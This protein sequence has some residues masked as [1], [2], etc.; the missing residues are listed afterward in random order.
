MQHTSP[1]AYKMLEGTHIEFLSKGVK[2]WN[3]WRYDKKDVQP[4]LFLADLAGVD[5]SSYNLSAANLRGADLTR[6]DLSR[7]DLTDATLSYCKLCDS[8]LLDAKLQGADL[9]RGIIERANFGGADLTG[10][11]LKDAFLSNVSFSGASLRGADLSGANLNSADLRNVDLINANLNGANLEGANLFNANLSYSSL[12]NTNLA[13]VN[14]TGAR[15]EKTDLSNASAINTNFASVNLRG[16]YGLE[17]V[18]HR[19]PSDISPSTIILS[20]Q[21]IP[22]IFLRGCGLKD[23]EIEATKLHRPDLTL[24]QATDILYKVL[25]LRSIPHIQFYS[26]FISHSSVD[27]RFA[28]RLYMDLQDKGVRCWYAPE[29]M[30]IGDR[31]R[32]R[33]D[34][35]IRLHDKTLLVLSKTSL[36]S[37]WVEQEVETALRKEREQNCEVLFPVRVDD[38]VMKIRSGWPALIKDTRHIGDFCQWGDKDCYSK[39]FSQLLKSLKDAS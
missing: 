39:S 4:Y 14:L 26:C 30:K 17:A 10:A 27:I 19:G 13:S 34:E 24:D 36:Y 2:T 12:T 21:K 35:S 28:E 6:A 25:E 37:Q 20:G 38:E 22:E 11:I 33:I 9:Y 16:A 7:A 29:D 8:T 15:L 23:W 3:S 5:L 18:T 1:N 31:I 32:N